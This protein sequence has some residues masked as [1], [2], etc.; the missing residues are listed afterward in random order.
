VETVKPAADAKSIKLDLSLDAAAGPIAADAGRMQQ[1]V[2]NILSNAIKFT[3]S[4][5]TVRIEL[6]R[7]NAHIELRVSDTGVGISKDFMPH[8]FERFRQG[9][10]SS[11]RRYG[12]LGLG[13]SIVKSL[14]ELHGGTVS[15]TSPGEGAGTT[16]TVR[17]PLSRQGS[18][19]R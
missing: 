4:D 9:D 5:G 6:A 12:G 7:A 11:S 17:L 18:M 3:P 13:L 2:W 14:V 16:V 15:V 1:V 8:L 10:A 19:M